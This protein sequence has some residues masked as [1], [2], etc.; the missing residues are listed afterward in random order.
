MRYRSLLN[1]DKVKE[2][3]SPVTITVYTKCPEK[4]MLVDM[5]TG[6]HYIGTDKSLEINEL[7]KNMKSSTYVVWDKMV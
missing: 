5:E 4:W 7:N 2:L 3:D 1:G 6:Q